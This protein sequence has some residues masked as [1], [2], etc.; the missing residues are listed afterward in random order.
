MM[1]WLKRLMGGSDSSS[2]SAE[3]A[4]APEPAVV[5]SEPAIDAGAG[6]DEPAADPPAGDPPA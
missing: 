4:T 5:P 3:P 1:N 2:E 6:V